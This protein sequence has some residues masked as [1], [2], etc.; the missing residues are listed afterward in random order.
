MVI[1]VV[2]RD[3]QSVFLPVLVGLALG[4][5]T[6]LTNG[7]LVRLLKINPLIVT[8]AMNLIWGGTA[9]VVSNGYAI[10]GFSNGFTHIGTV[11][12]HG[13]PGPG[14]LALALFAVGGF[15]LVATRSGLRVYAIG[16]NPETA[17]A[18]GIKADRIVTTLFALNG[19]L[20]GIVAI[21][22][23]AEQANATPQIGT[24]FA[25]Q[26]LTAVILGG[27]AFAGGGGNPLGVFIGIATIGILQSGLIFLGIQSWYQDIVQERSC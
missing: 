17:R 26:V 6:G 12:F 20:L 2:A 16:G 7:L 14:F 10:Y 19:V 4:L 23:T 9:Y 3:T 13:I 24:N 11:A 8:L 18:V 5:G 22:N 1:A 21:L 25:L 27:V 15:L